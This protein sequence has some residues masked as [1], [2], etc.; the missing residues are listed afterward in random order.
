MVKGSGR[1][2]YWLAMSFRARTHGVLRGPILS[3]AG[4]RAVSPIGAFQ[5]TMASFHNSAVFCAIRLDPRYRDDTLVFKRQ[6]S[7]EPLVSYKPLTLGHA[8]AMA[9]A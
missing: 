6:L 5:I 3:R 2:A 1:H 7:R 8:P 4:Y 9:T